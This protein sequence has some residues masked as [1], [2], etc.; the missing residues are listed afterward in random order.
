MKGIEL[1]VNILIIVAVAVIVLI[2]VIAMFY[3]PFTSGT[4]SIGIDT[5]KSNACRAML[6]NG[7]SVHPNTIAVYGFDA[8]KDGSFD[9]GNN[10]NANCPPATDAA[11]KDTLWSLC[12]CQLGIDQNSGCS[13]CLKDVC[14]CKTSPAGCT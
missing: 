14:G 12:V 4:N 11:T 13:E 1:P 10:G 6:A 2:A 8:D 5:A 3:K 7:C 9:P